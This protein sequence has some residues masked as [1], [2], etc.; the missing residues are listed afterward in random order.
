MEEQDLTIYAENVAVEFPFAPS[1]HTQTLNS[2]QN[3][4]EFFA[5]IGTFA[6]GH[7]IELLEASAFEGGF[8]LEYRESSTFRATGRAYASRIVWTACIEDGRIVRLREYYDPLRV[9]EALG[10]R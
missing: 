4:G 2:A 3:L 10:E 1:D 7:R 5:N 6:S 9:L 8:T